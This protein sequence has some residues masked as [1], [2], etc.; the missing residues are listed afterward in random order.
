MKPLISFLPKPE[1]M[2][3]QAII[4]NQINIKFYEIS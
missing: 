3:N 2:T 4:T 1:Q